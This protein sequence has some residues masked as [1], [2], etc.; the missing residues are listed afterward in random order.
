MKK[1][2][3][4]YDAWA[5]IAANVFYPLFT[6][7]YLEWTI[8]TIMFMYIVEIGIS[9]LTNLFKAL[10]IQDKELMPNFFVKLFALFIMTFVYLVFYVI[11][12]GYALNLF[13]P[14]DTS[15]QEW[16]RIKD[17]IALALIGFW[18]V[19]LGRIFFFFY[20]QEY[21]I[22]GKYGMG[23]IIARPHLKM[24]YTLLMFMV[25]DQ[26]ILNEPLLFLFIFV[27]FKTPIEIF[28]LKV[29]RQAPKYPIS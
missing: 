1:N 6:L 15:D 28:L 13:M 7:Y 16:L 5:T 24:M 14:A 29:E 22:Y 18:L 9:I 12:S 2:I 27:L 17:Q 19:E 11:L 10:F 4:N 8:A 25:Y 26:S 21:K 23:R 3:P 20:N